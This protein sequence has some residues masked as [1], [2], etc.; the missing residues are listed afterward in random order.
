MDWQMKYEAGAKMRARIIY[1]DPTAKR[2]CLSLLPHLVAG[3]ASPPLPPINSLFQV[4][5]TAAGV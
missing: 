1:V 5:R 4:Q 2:V 3:L